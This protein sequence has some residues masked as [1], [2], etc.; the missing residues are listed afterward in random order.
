MKYRGVSICQAALDHYFSYDG[1]FEDIDYL[2][3]L[4]LQQLHGVGLEPTIFHKSSCMIVLMFEM[5]VCVRGLSNRWL[6]DV[7]VIFVGPIG[8]CRGSYREEKQ[9][10]VGRNA[11]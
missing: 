4:G 9:V 2:C 10:R 6:V 5:E 1:F 8:G 3:Y 7:E 11:F